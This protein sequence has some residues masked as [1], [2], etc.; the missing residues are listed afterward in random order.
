M[1]E[2]F[3]KKIFQNIPKVPPHLAFPSEK[4]KRAKAHRLVVSFS[5]PKG[6]DIQRSFVCEKHHKI[7][8]DINNT[9]LIIVCGETFHVQYQSHVACLRW[10]TT[11]QTAR[12]VLSRTRVLPGRGSTQS[13]E[14]TG[15]S[16]PD[17]DRTIFPTSLCSPEISGPEND[18]I[19]W[20]LSGP[21]RCLVLLHRNYFAETC[22]EN[23]YFRGSN[24]EKDS[25]SEKNFEQG[26]FGLLPCKPRISHQ[27]QSFCAFLCDCYLSQDFHFDNCKQGKKTSQ[28]YRIGNLAGASAPQ[29]CTSMAGFWNV[30]CVFFVLDEWDGGAS[31]RV[32]VFS[33][34]CSS[35]VPS[36]T[37]FHNFNCNFYDCVLVKVCSKK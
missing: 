26:T 31:T 23:G 21:S 35:L 15:V 1:A 36:P 37:S 3:V 29:K 5:Q 33:V 22:S 17:N 12:L 32:I 18:Q 28:E 8:N 19:V 7:W 34:R 2:Q 6:P 24:R 30:C 27:H 4:L 20:S 14:S 9:N 10:K 11:V 13:S 16:G 25:R